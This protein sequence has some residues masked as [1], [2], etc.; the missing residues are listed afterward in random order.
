[1]RLEPKNAGIQF[2]LGNAHLKSRRIDEAIATFKDCLAADPGYAK[3][4]MSLGMA[5]L[6][7]GRRAE[8]IEVQAKLQPINPIMAAQLQSLL[9]GKAQLPPLE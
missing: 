9:D 3:G 1:V 8:A 5:Y 4:W 7:V 6:F 2:N